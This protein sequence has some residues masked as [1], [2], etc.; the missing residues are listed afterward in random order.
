MNI[1]VVD[2][3]KIVCQ[4]LKTIIE[5]DEHCKVVGIGHNYK[6]ALR[7]YEHHRPD[8][9][10]LDIRM[11]EQTGLDAG[12]RIIAEDEA[13]KVL[14]LTTFSDD[15][16]VYESLKMG[17]KGYL[18]KQD[19]KSIL[20]AIQAVLAGQHVFG[21]EIV[22]KL[23]ELLKSKTTEIKNADLTDREKELVRLVAEGY[24]NKE[25]AQLLYLSDGTVRNYLTVLLE[26]LSLRDRT[27]LAI[28]YYKQVNERLS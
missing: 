6:D 14:F 8:L 24:N 2:D 27:Q 11:G 17:A 12:K 4:A 1:V 19:F 9:V 5:A 15:E 18:L 10:L 28:Y 13:A 16:Y 21:K 23:P 26:K 7:L 20:P 3:D 25:I 22:D